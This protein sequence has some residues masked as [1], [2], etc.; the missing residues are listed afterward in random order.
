MEAAQQPSRPVV[1]PL[2]ISEMKERCIVVKEELQVSFK[3]ANQGGY[4]FAVSMQSLAS[5]KTEE[6]HRVQV[7]TNLKAEVKNPCT[8][9]FSVVQQA[10]YSSSHTNKMGA[11]P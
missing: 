9:E 4:P 5:S 3:T 1:C 8:T 10:T 2:S 7:W 11:G 6:N